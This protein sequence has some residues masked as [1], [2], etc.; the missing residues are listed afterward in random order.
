MK[1]NVV[2]LRTKRTIV[3]DSHQIARL[4]GLQG[5]QLKRE[6]ISGLYE[7]ERSL[8]QSPQN[9]YSEDARVGIISLINYYKN[10]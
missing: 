2:D 7:I 9:E 6:M 8:L 10:I 4:A 5:R 3:S 1:N